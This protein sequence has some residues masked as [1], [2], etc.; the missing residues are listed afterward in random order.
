VNVDFAYFESREL[1]RCLKTAGWRVEEATE[2][3]PYAPGVETQTRRVYI[4]ATG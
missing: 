1:E 4:V 2:R 3:A